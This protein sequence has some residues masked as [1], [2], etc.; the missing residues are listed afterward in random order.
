[1]TG[2]WATWAGVGL[3]LGSAFGA[4]AGVAGIVYDALLITKMT[5]MII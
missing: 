5:N 4:G 1:M 3:G 2:L